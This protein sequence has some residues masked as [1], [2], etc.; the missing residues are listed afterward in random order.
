MRENRVSKESVENKME[1]ANLAIVF[2]PTLMR[3][4]GDEGESNATFFTNMSL[5]NQLIADLIGQADWV[6]DSSI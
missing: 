4:P 2:G 5:Q 6:F 3:A 1:I